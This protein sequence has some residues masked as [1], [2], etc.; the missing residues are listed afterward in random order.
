M[1]GKGGGDGGD[2][3]GEGVSEGDDDDNNDNGGD[4]RRCISLGISKEELELVGHGL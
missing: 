4:T 2:D 3:N 1:I